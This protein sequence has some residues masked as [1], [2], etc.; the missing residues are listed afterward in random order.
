M[1]W[2]EQLHPKDNK[3]DKVQQEVRARLDAKK[4]VSYQYIEALRELEE[5]KSKLPDNFEEL[6]Q[7]LSS[8]KEQVRKLTRQLNRMTEPRPFDHHDA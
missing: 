6:V 1:S 3:E 5:V 4:K 8:K 7:E 2:K